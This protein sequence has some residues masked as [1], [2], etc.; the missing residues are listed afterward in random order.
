MAHW[1]IEDHGFGGQYY[2]CSNCGEV[3]NDIFHDVGG[4]DSCPACGEPIDID[5]NEYIDEVRPRRKDRQISCSVC[6]S[7]E[8][9]QVNCAICNS[10]YHQEVVSILVMHHTS[11]MSTTKIIETKF[12]PNCGRKFNN[13]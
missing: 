6:K 1:I 2:T 12:C 5:E 11:D 9:N 13:D 4:E 3:W 7:E 10:D 8:D